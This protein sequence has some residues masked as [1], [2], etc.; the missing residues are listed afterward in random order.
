ME[1][2]TIVAMG[3]VCMACFLMGAKVAQKAGKGEEINMPNVPNPIEAIRERRDKKEAEMAQDRFE[4]IMRNIDGYDGTG[5]G[6]KD[7]PKG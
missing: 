5:N 7:V 2:V 6:Q 3:F 4:T 1:V